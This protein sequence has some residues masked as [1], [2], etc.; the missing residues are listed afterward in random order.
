MVTFATMVTVITAG[1]NT[2]I[3]GTN[4]D[5]VLNCHAAESGADIAVIYTIFITWN[6]AFCHW[7]YIF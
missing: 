1:H 2:A 7:W 6:I 4:V 5:I 3:V